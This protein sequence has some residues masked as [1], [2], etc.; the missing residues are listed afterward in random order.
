MK[1][2]GGRMGEFLT[3]LKGIKGMKGCSAGLVGNLD[4]FQRLGR[5]TFT[6][7]RGRGALRK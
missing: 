2:M 1:D 3:W 5:T 6:Q 7:W 4:R